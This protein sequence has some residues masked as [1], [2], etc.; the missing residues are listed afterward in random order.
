MSQA[1][2]SP[3]PNLIASL[4]MFPLGMGTSVSEQVGKAYQSIRSIDG[5]IVEPNAMSTIIEANSLEKIWE[6]VSA[7]HEALLQIG[8]QRIY[9]VLTLDDRRDEPHTA[10]QKVA[11]MIGND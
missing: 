7:A 2:P 8:S 5:I 6:A 4:T 3:M 10:E 1:T 11:R 9:M